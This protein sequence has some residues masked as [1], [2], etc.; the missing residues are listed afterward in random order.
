MRSIRSIGIFVLGIAV[1]AGKAAAQTT[2]D[3]SNP[4]DNTPSENLRLF[5]TNA[6]GNVIRAAITRHTEDTNRRVNNPRQGM[7]ASDGTRVGGTGTTGGATGTGTGGLGDLGALL[8]LAGLGDLGGL[9]GGLGGLG[10]LTGGTTG[11][12]TGTTGTGATGAT[13]SE[14]APANGTDF[15]VDD[16]LRLRDSLGGTAKPQNTAQ[17]KSNNPNG[18]GGAVSR[19]PD[20]KVA[21]RQQTTTP[22]TTPTEEPKFVTRLANS[23][24]NQVF[25]SLSA[26]LRLPFVADAIAD[27]I[28]GLMPTM[29]AGGDNGG[30]NGDGGDGGDNGGGNGDGGNGGTGDGSDGSIDDLD[31]PTD[32]GDTGSVI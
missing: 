21:Q 27:G 16:L 13:G 11:G 5:R 29:D 20:P 18:F 17:T 19:L 2:P 4:L 22:P 6:P 8:N 1:L 28:R 10:G 25:V 23:L 30:G 3:T 31:P 26:A 24:L 14:F 32:D 9:A 12:A 15:T 7:S